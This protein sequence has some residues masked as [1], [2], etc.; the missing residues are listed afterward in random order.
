MVLS[1]KKEVFL[2]IEFLKKK[3]KELIT[4]DGEEVK[5]ILGIDK[6][7]PVVGRVKNV[8][9]FLLFSEGKSCKG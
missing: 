8:M 7:S 3:S 2:V 5:R 4:V 6:P 1:I 9:E